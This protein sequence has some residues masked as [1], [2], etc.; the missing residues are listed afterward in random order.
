MNQNLEYYQHI[1]NLEEKIGFNFSN[2]MIYYQACTHR[3]YQNE[4]RNL[5]MNNERLEFLGDSVLSLVVSDFL[6]SNFPDFTEGELSFAK[7]K[8]IEAP[9]CA[10]YAKELGIESFLLLGKGEMQ[11]LGKGRDSVIADFFEA[12]IGAIF[13]DCGIAVA[14]N[15]L[16]EKFI[17]RWL[18]M[19]LKKEENEKVLLQEYSQKKFQMIPEY[20]VISE[21]GP[22]H[23][24]KFVVSVSI[25]GKQ[26]GEGFGSS[27]K[28]A[29]LNAAKAAIESLKSFEDI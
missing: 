28:Q 23:D 6:Y 22:D 25:Q 12:I 7:S 24:K 3:S 18:D 14:R 9:A 27:K 26:F 29:Q 4:M 21:E 5:N 17:K 13:L 19:G 11:N 15:F 2:P 8:I 10:A 1:K 16:I 20:H